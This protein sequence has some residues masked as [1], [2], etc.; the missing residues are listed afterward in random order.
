MSEGP[1]AI[2]KAGAVRIPIY[3]IPSRDTHTAKWREGGKSREKKCRD[4]EKLKREIK[5]IAKAID[6]RSV[7]FS[8][9][10]PSQRAACEEVIIRGITTDQLA[11]LRTLRPVTAREAADEFLAS[12]DDVSGPY[13]RSLKTQLVQFTRKFGKRELSS[14]TT[15]D[16]D[17]WL[18]TTASNLR[19]RTNKRSTI[20]SLWR[21]AR[22]KDY[23]PQDQRT[24]AERTDTPSSRRQKRD[25]HVETWTPAE[26]EKILVHCPEEYLPWIVFSAFAGIRTQEIFADEKTPARRKEVL[27]WEHVHL[28]GEEPRILV[29][30]AVSKTAEK[31]AVPVSPAMKKWLT[32][33]YRE[34]GPVCDQPCPWRKL[35]RWSS[36]S[37]INLI[38][39]A[40]GTEWK[41]NALRHSFGTYRV[42]LAK[43]AGEIALEMGNSERIVKKH[44]LDIG[45]TEAEAKAWFAI[46][47][48]K[49]KR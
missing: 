30:A 14:I 47:P 27:Q 34:S 22:D 1:V 3:Y 45:R 15:A 9:L 2:V 5:K 35:K 40:A 8:T 18:K 10:T 43:S 32:S 41:K 17:K 29:P 20:V 21:W 31:R 38:A 13:F 25:H 49:A 4:L 28:G 6:S 33:I 11:T 46:T 24:A 19:T 36:K 12:K 7:D 26:L 37:A 42:I 39:E 23:L 16:L 48:T 44:Y